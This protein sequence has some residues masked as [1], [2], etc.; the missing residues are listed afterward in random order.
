MVIEVVQV[1]DEPNV[2]YDITTSMPK[3]SKA[4]VITV[5]NIIIR[6]LETDMAQEAK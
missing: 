5:L 2:R 6:R 4:Q 1:G 3:I